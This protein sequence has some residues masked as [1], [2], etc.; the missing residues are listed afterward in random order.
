MNLVLRRLNSRQILLHSAES[1]LNIRVEH[2]HT[3]DNIFHSQVGTVGLTVREIISK[4][5]KGVGSFVRE[6]RAHSVAI[7]V[8][9]PL[10]KSLGLGVNL[11]L[12]RVK[13]WPS[14]GQLEARGLIWRIVA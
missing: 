1:N 12:K 11:L 8:V 14:V 3:R 13:Y 4:H 2:R 9:R 6:L 5:E 7:D 10:R